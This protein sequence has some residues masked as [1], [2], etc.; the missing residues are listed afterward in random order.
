MQPQYLFSPVKQPTCCPYQ[1]NGKV[2]SFRSTLILSKCS[3]SLG[4]STK[5]MQVSCLH[6]ECLVFRLTNS[7]EIIIFVEEYKL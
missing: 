2:S 7:T 4:S 3:D 1:N 5:L 6:N